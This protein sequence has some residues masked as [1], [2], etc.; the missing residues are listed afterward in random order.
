MIN[1]SKVILKDAISEIMKRKTTFGEIKNVAK[2]VLSSYYFKHTHRNPM[3]I[4]LI[5]NKLEEK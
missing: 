5:M 1:E 3:I 4:P 2:S